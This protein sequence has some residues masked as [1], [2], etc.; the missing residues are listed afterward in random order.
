MKDPDEIAARQCDV[1]VVAEGLAGEALA[2]LLEHRR[3]IRNAAAVRFE[4]VV[5]Q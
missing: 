5:V 1:R 3:N 2:A 4:N